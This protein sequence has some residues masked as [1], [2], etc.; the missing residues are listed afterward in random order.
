VHSEVAGGAGILGAVVDEQNLVRLDAEVAQHELECRRVGFGGTEPA[1]VVPVLEA[2]RPAGA[3]D[4]SGQRF[5]RV[6]QQCQPGAGAHEG[7]QG[8]WVQPEQAAHVDVGQLVHDP[9]CRAQVA[10]QDP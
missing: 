8:E 3:V 10:I 5:R 4:G 7:G 9:R 6:G 1:A 2:P